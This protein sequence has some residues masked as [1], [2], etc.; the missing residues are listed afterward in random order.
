MGNASV[1]L[2]SKG[3]VFIPKHIRDE[4][5]WEAGARLSLISGPGGIGCEIWK[6]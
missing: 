4:L 3:Q 2:S 6:R 1:T 5:H